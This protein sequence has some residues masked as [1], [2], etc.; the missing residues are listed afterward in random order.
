MDFSLSAEQ[1]AIRSAI[2]RVCARFDDDYWL[3]KDRN[4]GFPRDFH[5]TFADDGWLGI[6][7]PQAHGG[8]GLGVT[9]AALICR[10]SPTPAPGCPA[11]R[12][13]T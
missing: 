4:G 13:C 7:I 12:R 6:C 3:A 1:A 5:R 2:E 8:S 9:E 10:P 11:P